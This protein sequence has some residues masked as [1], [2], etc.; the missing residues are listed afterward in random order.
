MNQVLD[1][2]KEAA[3]WLD[4]EALQAIT[5]N[6]I[7][8]EAGALRHVAPYLQDRGFKRV[9]IAADANTHAAAGMALW[10]RIADAGI[11]V[12][13]T[14]IKPD[15]QGDV[16]ADEASLVQ[17]LTDIR[18]TGAELVI[19]VGSGTIHDIVRYSA[20][21]AGISFVSVPTAPSVDG[22]NSKGAPLIIRGEKKTFAA[23]APDAI[24]ADLDVLCAAP[25]AM[26][27]AGF[28]DMLGKYTSLFDWVYG[29]AAGDE[30]YDRTAAA[31]TAYALDKCVKHAES[32][33]SRDQDGIRVLTE[34]LI[35]SGLAMLL[36][37]Q[38]HPAAGAEHHLSHYWEM[39]YLR[40][41]RRS[42]LH[43]AKVGVASAAIAGVYRRIAEEQGEALFAADRER[44]EQALAAVPSTAELQRLLRVVGGP[45]TAS[46][47]GIDDELLTRSLR[48]AHRVRVNRQ[49]LLKA[50]NE[51]PAAVV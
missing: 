40:L 32:I 49:T 19:A 15:A 39:E 24:F 27:A 2:L 25:S 17:L 21:L 9:L 37:G 47:L 35:E 34:A 22:F 36:F 7:I 31:I 11:S 8:I 28:G 3:P 48:E 20:C 12:Q 45:A 41:G 46:E 30:P 1:N 23:I 51:L 16:I 26:A 38:S 5:V 18:Q 6:P 44:L 29:A 50:Y 43:G 14:L 42:L 13:T 10:P 33:G 4:E